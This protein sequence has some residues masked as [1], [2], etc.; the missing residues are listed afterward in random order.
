MVAGLERNMVSQG[1]KSGLCQQNKKVFIIMMP[2][3]MVIITIRRRTETQKNT[4]GS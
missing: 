1:L 4:C 3:M 2:M